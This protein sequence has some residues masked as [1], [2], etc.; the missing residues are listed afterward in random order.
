MPHWISG[1]LLLL[2]HYHTV[3]KLSS[4]EQPVKASLWVWI[5]VWFWACGGMGCA[6]M[7]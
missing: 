1:L 7:K 6:E 5:W 3:G 2:A 4:R